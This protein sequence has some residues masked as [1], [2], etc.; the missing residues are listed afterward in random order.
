[1]AIAARGFIL[2]FLNLALLVYFMSYTV[3]WTKLCE[4]PAKERRELQGRDNNVVLNDPEF[5]EILHAHRN[6]L[7]RASIDSWSSDRN[8]N[9]LAVVPVTH[10]FRRPPKPWETTAATR[11]EEYP[12]A[13]EGVTRFSTDDLRSFP[14]QKKQIL[15][16]SEPLPKPQLENKTRSYGPS[17]DYRMN[18]KE[19]LKSATERRQREAPISLDE[20]DQR[21]IRPN[22]GQDFNHDIKN[23]EAGHKR[24]SQQKEVK[25]FG[26]PVRVP[27]PPALPRNNND[28]YYY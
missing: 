24:Q 7:P 13:H 11:W 17:T 19:S 16:D 6:K 3:N 1:M 8:R 23:F 28:S 21:V 14:P 10:E 26:Q 25:P 2:W 27:P 12:T 18:L 5:R 22:R 4:P 15:W 9:D 20:D